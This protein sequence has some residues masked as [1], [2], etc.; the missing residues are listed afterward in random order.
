MKIQPQKNGLADRSKNSSEETERL[1]SELNHLKQQL[2]AYRSREYG[3]LEIM[4]Q[5]V[6]V[7]KP[8]GEIIYF[9][10]CWHEYTGLAATQSTRKQ[11][12][13]T[14][15]REDRDRFIWE[16]EE[17]RKKQLEYQ[18]KLSLRGAEG[19]YRPFSLLVKPILD[20]NNKLDRWVGIFTEI[21][22]PQK[23]KLEAKLQNVEERWQLAL[24]GIGDGIFDWNIMTGECFLSEALKGML[25][26]ED[27]EIANTYEGWRSLLHPEDIDRVEKELQRHLEGSIP[28]YEI[29]Y[30]LRCNDGSYKWI[31]ARGKVKWDETGKAIRMVGSHCDISDRK[32]A[33]ALLKKSEQKYRLLAEN[34]TDLISIQT[35]EKIYQYVSPACRNLLGYEAEEL[36][37]KSTYQFFHPDDAAALR[38]T[39]QTVG[40]LPDKITHRYRLRHRDG[41]YIWVEATDR[42]IYSND[43]K[44][45][46]K[47]I[48]TARDISDRVRVEEEVIEL[49]LELE[50]R[51]KQRT[52]ELEA[53]N[54]LKDE[55]LAWEKQARLKIQLYADI[56]SNI[57]IGFCVWKLEDINDMTSFRLV[58]ANPAASKLL[59]MKLEDCIGQKMTECFPKL[60]EVHKEYLEAYAEVVRTQKAREFNEIYYSDD[61]LVGGI[62]AIKAFPLPDNCLGLGFEDITDRKQIEKALVESNRQYTNVVNSVREVIFQTDIQGRLTFLNR[63]WSKI[64][65]FSREESLGFPLTDYLF[66][67]TDKKRAAK[68]FQSIVTKKK[69]FCQA[70]FQ[71]QTKK[72]KF[73]WLEIK[74]QLDL[75]SEGK[76]LGTVG[77][78]DDISD[79]KLIETMLKERAEELTKLNNSLKATTKE[80]ERRNKELDRFAHV[81]SHDLKEPLR[82]IGKLS[83]W[84]SEDLKDKLDNNTSRQLDML[85]ARVR[86]MQVFIDALLQYS[87][88][89][90]TKVEPEIVNARE[91]LTEIIDNLAPPSEFTIV[92]DGEMPVFTT[93][94]LPLQQVFSNLISNAIKHHHR[95]DGQVKISSQDRGEFYQFTVA[96]NGPGIDP[97]YHEKIFMIFKTVGD[98]KNGQN[99]GIGLSIVK[100]NIENLGGTIE[101]ESIVDRGTTFRFTWP[102]N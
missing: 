60:M 78:M 87:R 40:K 1:R 70:E 4:P 27:R 86:R 13:Q 84:L 11:F 68:L 102:K 62:Y 21:G 94:R 30:R 89:G 85:E 90:R 48:S 88:L 81:V 14:I 39:Y 101:I 80:L 75:D 74:F 32:I 51:V 44:T 72:D 15:H 79:R 53:A 69:K 8:N 18:T 6:W 65:G 29:Q 46:E 83:Q 67:A 7:A 55:L 41:N 93:E 82:A 54:F 19:S 26:Y 59:S 56:I 92:I 33:E 37:G 77:T 10:R 52:V 58:A 99:T 9:N 45:I 17:A 12:F 28:Q 3:L 25:G 38:K 61:R 20:E 34:S 100:K 31:L 73:R 16:W 5:I 2:K 35:L 49:N 97:M 91:L 42:T 36:V 22:E 64:T 23:Q 95:C 57:Q 24:E 43:S 63:A 96:D 50:N 47:I 76:V 71:I 98:H 66:D